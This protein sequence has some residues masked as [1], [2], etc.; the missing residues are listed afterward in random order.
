MTFIRHNFRMLWFK[1]SK[2]AV[3]KYVNFVLLVIYEKVDDLL[4]LLKDYSPFNLGCSM[5]FIRS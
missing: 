1:A 2:L 3:D 4:F 5:V